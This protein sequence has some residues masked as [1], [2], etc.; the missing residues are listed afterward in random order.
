MSDEYAA[1]IASKSQVESN[2]GIVSR[3]L[4]GF[5]FDFQRSL[6]EWSLAK[7]RAAIFADC[8]MGKTPM[9]LAWADQVV[10]HTNG[11]VLILTPLAV[12]SQTVR[13]SEKFGIEAARSVSGELNSRIVVTNYER[14]HKFNASDFDGVVCDESSILKSFDGTTKAAITEFMRTRQF[15]LLCT[16]TAAPN[17]FI[18]LGSSSE[19]LGYMGFMDMLTR[20]FKNN[21]NNAALQRA[22]AT[23]GGG[24]P[25]WTFKGHAERPFW[26][27][28]A[29]WARSL[30]KP[31]DLGFDDRDFVLPKLIERRHIVEA[32][33]A[34]GM[35]FSMPAVGL[36]E[37]RAER[38][39]T[40]AERCEFA[41]SLVNG[42]SDPAVCWVHLNDEG[43]LLERMIPDAIQVSG[44]D[45]DDEKE[46]KLESFTSGSARVL[47][48]KPIIGAWGLN[49]Q[50]CAHMTT[51]ASHSFEQSYQA[52]RRMLRFGQKR[53]VVVDHILTNGET[54]VL[55]NLR[56][57]SEQAERMFASM[58][59]CM[60]EAMNPPVRAV[61]GLKEEV[62]SWLV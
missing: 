5:L 49:W 34:E 59:E 62:P 43:D 46:S 35:L 29:S 37:E 53:D 12:A 14:L 38:R 27:W 13:E 39:R 40:L 58:V 52:I 24:A 45:S 19:A 8:G 6:V 36:Q 7:G 22:W 55:A 51:F 18:E 21:R 42:T 2:G 28:V 4:P 47:V 25:Q 20:F 15:R 16:A 30:R 60:H 9:Q 61:G 23:A 32:P 3:E 26:R 33:P 41:A 44:K 57:K 48:T 11:R 56:R 50:H 1:F 10:R 17:D 31:S 54:N